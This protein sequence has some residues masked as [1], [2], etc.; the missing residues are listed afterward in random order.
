MA[1]Q[2][3]H[4]ILPTL[5]IL[6]F[7]LGAGRTV[8]NPIGHRAHPA[9]EEGTRK[10]GCFSEPGITLSGMRTGS[11]AGRNNRA[12]FLRIPQPKLQSG[13]STHAHANHMG[14]FDRETPHDSGDVIDRVLP[15]IQCRVFGNFAR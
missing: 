13:I 3:I 10:D 7:Q 8:S 12:G 14:A 5:R 6:V 11:Y 4:E 2:T 15:A 9:L 1:T